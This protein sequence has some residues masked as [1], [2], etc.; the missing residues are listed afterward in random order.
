MFLRGCLPYPTSPVL[1]F[2]EIAFVISFATSDVAL[3]RAYHL[4]VRV[5]FVSRA[6]Q[7]I[8]ISWHFSL[9]TRLAYSASASVSE[10]NTILYPPR[11]NIS[12]RK[13]FFRGQI[14]LVAVTCDMSQRT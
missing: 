3:F 11:A 5:R 4:E 8:V 12:F 10:T 7:M 14:K 6:D 9:F 2:Q 13:Y 1:R